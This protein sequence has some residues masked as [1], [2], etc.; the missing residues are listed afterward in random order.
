MSV[1]TTN[2]SERLARIETSRSRHAGTIALHVGEREVYV[3]SLESMRVRESLGKRILGNA[4]YPLSFIFAFAVG[5]MALPISVAIRARV[6]PF[7]AAVDAATG[8]APLIVSMVLG[9]MTSVVLSQLFRMRAKELAT[10]QAVG[11]WAA[12]SLMHNLAFWMPDLSS[13]LFTPEW[14]ALQTHIAMPDSFMFRG[15][16]FQ[17]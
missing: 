14:V 3:R 10:A 7:P 2:F 12:V 6:S 15:L 16:V 11:V 5:A 8:D 9:M 17:F 4:L 1:S 13:L